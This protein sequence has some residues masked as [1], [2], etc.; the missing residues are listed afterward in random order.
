MKISVCGVNVK[1][2]KCK[3]SSIPRPECY[4]VFEPHKVDDYFNAD[5]NQTYEIQR[6]VSFLNFPNHQIMM[7]CMMTGVACVDA[8]II[9]T[10]ADAWVNAQITA[11]TR[12]IFS[13]VNKLNMESVLIVQTKIDSVARK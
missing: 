3:D 8:V 9:L 4:R 1:I 6:H 7:A 11:R 13:C 2:Y 10:A 12:N 5:N